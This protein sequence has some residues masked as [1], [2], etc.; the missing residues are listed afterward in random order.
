MKQLFRGDIILVNLGQNL[1]SSVQSGMRPCLVISSYPNS[2]IVNVCPFTSK[3]G[4]K[5][6]SV[7][8]KVEPSEVKGNL[9]K[10]SI[11]LVEQITTINKHSILLKIG[12][13]PKK[14]KI[15]EKIDEAIIRQLCL[16]RNS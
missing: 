11:L 13:I 16:T 12:Y 4:K 2:T 15:M 9:I 10:P 8:V 7:H 5:L 3:I 1:N 6:I 14:S